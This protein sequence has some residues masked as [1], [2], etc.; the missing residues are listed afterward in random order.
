MVKI[1]ALVVGIGGVFAT[2]FGTHPLTTS[3][4]AAS[5]ETP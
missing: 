5:Q 1:L 3:R 4:P 2:R